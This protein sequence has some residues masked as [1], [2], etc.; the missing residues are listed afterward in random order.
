MTPDNND[1][2]TFLKNTGTTPLI[3]DRSEAEKEANADLMKEKLSRVRWRR[4][5]EGALLL[6]AVEVFVFLIGMVLYLSRGRVLKNWKRGLI[7]EKQLC[8]FGVIMHHEK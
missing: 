6:L 4:R 1:L 5:G 2:Q 7:H 3:V 8:H